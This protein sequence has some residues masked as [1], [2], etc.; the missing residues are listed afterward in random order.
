MPRWFLLTGTAVLCWGVWAI[1]SKLIGDAVTASQS[2]ALSTL[3]LIP[4]MIALACSKKLASTGFR[5]R[6]A[7]NAFLAGAL[8]CAGN[9]AYYYALSA[10]A[11]AATVVPLTAL[12]PLVTIGLAVL[13]LRERLNRVQLAGVVLSLVAIYLFNVPTEQ[14]VVNPWLGFAFLPIALWGVSGLLQ[15]MSTNDISGEL[16]TLLFL[17]AFVP[18]GAG[19]L[20]FQP[21]GS[22]PTAKVWLL[23]IALGLS[24]GLGNYAILLAFAQDGKASVI[25]PLAGLYPLISVPIAIFFLGEKINSREMAGI[26][27]AL[28]SVVALAWESPVKD[29]PRSISS[30]DPNEINH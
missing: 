27:V 8:T 23:V 24:F 7:L 18:V 9:V 16:S 3:G 12:Y 6:G 25:A 28:G 21:L 17:A 10:G 29:L 30:F 20:L 11:K 14:A 5:R 22:L 2:Q 4:V 15:K 1:I 19:L 13:L 26:A